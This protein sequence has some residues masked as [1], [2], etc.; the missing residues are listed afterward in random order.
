[1]KL[2]YAD[3]RCNVCLNQI[4]SFINRNIES[5]EST[6]YVCENCAWMCRLCDE[7]YTKDSFFDCCR[8]CDPICE[9]C[10]VI[11]SLY[12]YESYCCN[13]N[14]I[15]CDCIYELLEL[16]V[17]NDIVNIIKEYYSNFSDKVN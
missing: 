11:C 17:I 15:R 1:M 3:L 8:N 16:Y 14:E 9:E 2:T 10:A 4:Q 12:C 13:C 5:E 6:D 7:I